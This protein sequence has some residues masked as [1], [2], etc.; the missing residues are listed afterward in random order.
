[1]G[2]VIVVKNRMAHKPAEVVNEA[3]VKKTERVL[4]AKRSLPA[5]TFLHTDQDLEWAELPAEAILPNY[6][7]E[8]SD[9]L[10]SYE[11]GVSRQAFKAAEPV[12]PTMVVKRGAGGFLSAVL[13][14]G[15]RAVSLDVSPT[16]SAAGFIFPGDHVDLIVA[17][18]VN[19]NIDPSTQDQTIVSDTFVQNVRVVAVDQMLDNPENKAILAK[20]ITVEVSPQEA[21]RVAVAQQ[22]GIISFTL[23]SM[24]SDVQPEPVDSA[25]TANTAADG[26]IPA[27]DA[28]TPV[29]LKPSTET[30]A[31]MQE[32]DQLIRALQSGA[33]ITSST[34][35]VS[36]YTRA[37][38]VSPSLNRQGEALPEMLVIHGDQRERRT[39]TQDHQ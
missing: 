26:A 35:A 36:T 3:P 20:T 17:H 27:T 23:R 6:I 21:E 25:N 24:A 34:P 13:E 5:G 12:V 37:S 38:D 8:G 9:S 15:K 11:G 2:M 7:H 22:L 30:A 28:K 10:S 16:T 32:E 39:F 19:Y 18:K 31:S 33:P 1:M 29:A 4:V 14:P